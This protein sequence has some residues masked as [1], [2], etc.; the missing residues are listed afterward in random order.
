MRARRASG[1]LGATGAP[2]HGRTSGGACHPPSGSARTRAGGVASVRARREDARIEVWIHA[3]SHPHRVAAQAAQAEAWG[4]DGLLLADSQNL[5]ADIWIELA[6]AAAATERLGLGPGVTNPTT[7][8]PAVTASA[9][10]TLQAESSGR[11]VLGIGRGD[12]ALAQIGRSPVSAA[13]LERALVTIQGYL[14]GEAVERDGVE[15]RIGWI[16]ELDQPKVPLAVAATGLRVIEVGARHAEQVNLTVGAEP[17]R[18]RWAVETARAAAGERRDDVS[19]GAYVNV[20]VHRD[21]AVARDLI[22]GSTAI[23][24][25]FATAGAPPDGLSAVTREGIAALAHDYDETRHGQAAAA[26]RLGDDFVDRFAVAGPAAEVAER[27]AGLAELGIDRLIVV[28][29]S[30]DADPDLVVET[31]A[32]FA[33]AVLPALR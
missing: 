5:N 11:A 12:S 1:G 33:A 2:P 30:V 6:L 16:G 21:R 20:A 26:R 28:P 13:E 8:D 22:R 4:F 27:L 29:G 3:F 23:L 17:E 25:R 24:A 19:L 10:A 31:N 9:A 7:R 32:A 15:S 18:L 14:R